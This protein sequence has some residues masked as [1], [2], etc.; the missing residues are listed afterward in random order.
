MSRE[1]RKDREKRIEK[2]AKGLK[3]KE[4]RPLLV[5]LVEFGITAE[6]VSF[7]KN[8][9]HPCWSNTGEPLIEGQECYEDED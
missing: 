7:Y 9:L 2:W 3:A 5:E 6:E 4:M 1:T 8:D